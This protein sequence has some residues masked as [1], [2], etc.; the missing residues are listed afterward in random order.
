MALSPSSNFT[1][2]LK[3]NNDIFPLVQIGGSSTIYL[4]TRDVTVDSQAYDGRL[5][6]TPS[7]NSSIDLRNFTSRTSNITLRIVNAGYADTFGN[8]TNKTV[9][10]YFANNGTTSS[11]SDCLQVFV[12]RV[13]G[14]TKLTDR[15]I[16]VNCEDFAAWRF[17][18][19]LQDQ[20]ENESGYNVPVK[21]KFKSI[22][23]GDFDNNT[24]T[25]ASPG[26]CTNKFLRPAHLISHD[27][28][29][30]YYDQGLN[31]SAARGHVYV[32]S[33]DRFVPVENATTATTSKFG[34][35]V[36]RINNVSDT[37]NQKTFFKNTVR[38][39]PVHQIENSDVSNPNLDVNTTP[40]LAIN[41]DDA[42][43]VTVSTTG[44][45]SGS[46]AGILAAMSGQ[47]NGSV[48]K[49][50]A[51][52]IAE[53][54]AP[55]IPN[56]VVN[57]S[58]AHIYDNS[59]TDT[60]SGIHESDVTTANGWSGDNSWSQFAGTTKY[61]V[62]KDI[63]SDW[64]TGSAQ[65]HE[66]GVNLTDIVLGLRLLDDTNVRSLKV[67]SIYL[68]ITTYIELDKSSTTYNQ[69]SMGEQV[70]ETIYLGEDGRELEGSYVELDA[71]SGS[72]A[73]HGP[74]EVHENI[75]FNFGSGTGTVDT[76]S[77]ADVESN[78]NDFNEVRCTIDD[79][80]MTVQDALNKLQKEAG[81]IAYVKPSDGKI[82]YIMEDGS[83]KT[84]T[85]NLTQS[86]YRNATFGNI[87]LNKILWKVNYNYDKHPVTG[88]YLSSASY[89]ET[90]TKSTYD[91]TDNS[92]V[93]N[94]NQDWFNGFQG[95]KNL[96][97]LFK[98]QRVTAKC[99]I[100]DPVAW[101]LEIGDIITFSDPPADFR[102][103]R[104]STSAYTN[105]QFRITDTTRTVN[106]LKIKAMEVHK[107]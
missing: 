62:T 45:A 4:S 56:G 65:G 30:I 100:L 61:V 103:I 32:A 76:T 57:F 97:E 83:S 69:K 74:T 53:N 20:I 95:A 94:L 3:R 19:V 73:V 64:N 67:Y 78:Y 58:V 77:Q 2:A 18:K 37:T 93:L 13:I 66:P 79:E 92:G 35:N 23:Y 8:R 104:D 68:D 16:S 12:G 55:D 88:T 70:P 11:L 33:I 50:V 91:L 107:A 42:D 38:L 52:I 81:F 49:V 39:S 96:I 21:G 98:L 29:F 59:G 10:I 99:E 25:E 43:S 54:V 28:E 105:F 46:P 27:S 34:T 82:H 72:N 48:A 31:N 6:S 14:I 80:K 84:V 51:V 15:E 47:L 44:S 36:V 9:T 17:N 89:T 7:I 85:Q 101:K 86:M 63:T 87:S 24:S 90:A 1:N 102:Q 5:L 75:L 26:L 71:I 60:L 22:S 40:T 41:D 106:S